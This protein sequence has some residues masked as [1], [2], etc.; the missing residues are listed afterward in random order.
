V[1]EVAVSPLVSPRA[2]TCWEKVWRSPPFRIRGDGAK[3]PPPGS[4]AKRMPNGCGDPG[5]GMA[6]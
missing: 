4:R 3:T 1:A 6:G 2:E 5:F